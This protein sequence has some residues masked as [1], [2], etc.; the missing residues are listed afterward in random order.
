MCKIDELID[1]L[2]QNRRS[3]SIAEF[4]AGQADHSRPASCMAGEFYSKPGEQWPIN[5]HGP[6]I[7]LVQVVFGEVPIV[8]KCLKGLFLLTLFLDRKR[9]P[10]DGAANGN[11][12]LLRVYNPDD[13]L[14][15]LETPD[16]LWDGEYP[17]DFCHFAFDKKFPPRVTHLS[18]R[19]GDQDY[20]G[21]EDYISQLPRLTW[22]F[23][24]VHPQYV[25]IAHHQ[26]GTKVGGWPTYI[27]G[28]PVE[29][30]GEFAFQVASQEQPRVMFGD[31]GNV[32]V[33]RLQNDWRVW[34]DCY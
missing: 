17:K 30:Q 19:V 27:Q 7:P 12:W 1:V 9:L 29:S 4:V 10:R 5:D 13:V 3:S 21:W 28:G 22:E 25:Q 8:P 20:P 23:D 26:Y 16:A 32:Y 14:V 11:G 24:D 2:R 34:W 31:N 15:P 6:M 18:W 33:F